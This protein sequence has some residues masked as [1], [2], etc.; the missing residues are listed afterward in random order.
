MDAYICLLYL[1]PGLSS[2]G[3]VNSSRGHSGGLRADLVTPEAKVRCSLKCFIYLF[4]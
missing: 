4:I 2:T 1:M 3:H